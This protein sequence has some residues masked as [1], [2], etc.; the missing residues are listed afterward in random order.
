MSAST[1]ARWILAWLRERILVSSH[2]LVPLA[3]FVALAGGVGRVLVRTAIAFLGIVAFRLWDDVEDVPHDR[4]HHPTRVLCRLAS[5]R[6]P[7]FVALLGLTLTAALIAFTGGALW[8]FVGVVVAS[9]GAFAA[10]AAWP[11]LRLLFTHVL[12]LKVPALAL[13]LSRPEMPLF[14]KVGAVLSLYGAVTAY[15]LVHDDDARRAP[16]ASALALVDLACLFAGP[17]IWV[18][19]PRVF[20]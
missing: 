19:F 11:R 3:L 6:A 18:R 9:F 5:T 12:L 7:F 10:R 2:L 14:W 15:E 20:F 1:D 4:E 17:V 13:A 16:L 8:P